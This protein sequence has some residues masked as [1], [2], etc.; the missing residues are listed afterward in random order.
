MEFPYHGSQG[1]VEQDPLVAL[2]ENTR[3]EIF[4]YYGLLNELKMGATS[5]APK[6]PAALA[7]YQ[8]VKEFGIPLVAGG[9]MDQ[10]YIWLL[11]YEI[12]KQVSDLIAIQEQPK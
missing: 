12:A 11:Q 4:E 8:L 2:L 5:K 9:V 7:T 3:E 10:P 1:G 6:I